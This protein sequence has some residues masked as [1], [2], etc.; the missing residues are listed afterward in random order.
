MRL[1]SQLFVLLTAPG[2]IIHEIA[3]AEFCR[4][5]RIP[6]RERCYIQLTNPP[7]YVIHAEPR[8]YT[9]AV[10]IS[11]APL[12]VN[13][14]VAVVSGWTVAVIAVPITSLDAV[15]QLSVESL[16]FISTVGWIG[17]SSGIHALPSDQDALS[18]WNQTRSHW[19]NPLVLATLPLIGTIYLLNRFRQLYAH[20]IVGI[21]AFVIGAHIGMS[22]GFYQ[23]TIYEVIRAIQNSTTQS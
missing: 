20:V 5:F 17:I 21:G 15:F 13:V 4:Y 10:L 19:Y 1:I 9:V 12:L 3:H 6:V 23:D 22:P 18:L 7:G 2:I 8:R 14:A 11:F 16:V